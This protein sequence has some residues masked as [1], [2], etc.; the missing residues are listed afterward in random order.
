MIYKKIKENKKIYY[1]RIDIFNQIEW[2]TTTDFKKTSFSDVII[3][4]NK[5]IK[6]RFGMEQLVDSLMNLS[7]E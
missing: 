1:V 4:S 2:E 6:S 5:I 7:G 3:E